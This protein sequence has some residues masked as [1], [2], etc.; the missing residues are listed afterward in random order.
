MIYIDA[1]CHFDFD[2]APHA[3]GAVRHFICNATDESQW[4]GLS[5]LP[6]DKYSV[7][8]G[9]HPWHVSGA[10]P[11]WDLRLGDMLVR[12]PHAMVGEIGLDR[13]RDDF[14]L[15]MSVFRRQMEIAHDFNRAVHIH[16]VRAWDV[17]LAELGRVRLPAVVVHGFNA[18]ID[19]MHDLYRRGNVYMSFGASVL[20]GASTRLVAC[21]TD[22]PMDRILV[23]SDATPSNSDA[24]IPNIVAAIAKIKN[25][26]NNTTADIIYNNSIRII[27]NGQIAQNTDVAGGCGD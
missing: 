1:H 18:S 7:A 4:S 27:N 9:V 20:R 8:F 6:R 11:G 15:Q 16:C 17:M 3:G 12:F 24:V 23:E 19:I 26:D 10:A 2:A 14:E 5:D 25:I 21:I 13:A 22:T